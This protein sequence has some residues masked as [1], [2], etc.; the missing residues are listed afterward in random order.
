MQYPHRMIRYSLIVLFVLCAT[1]N[2]VYAAAEVGTSNT[3][4][5]MPIISTIRQ[6]WRDVKNHM[7]PASGHISSPKAEDFVC[8]PTYA[9]K[10]ATERRAQS[11]ADL[12]FFSTT[13]AKGLGIVCDSRLSA[14]M[15]LNPALFPELYRKQTEDKY[16]PPKSNW[17]KPPSDADQWGS[18]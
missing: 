4:S 12:K 14:C 17:V 10:E 1:D 11:N 7:Q 5:C 3:N 9:V 8:V 2:A 16:E 6:H 13:M 15:Q 18:N